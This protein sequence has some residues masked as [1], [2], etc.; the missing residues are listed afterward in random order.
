MME[1]LIYLK[2]YIFDI[3]EKCATI[4]CQNGGACA[5]SNLF[6]I[7]KNTATQDKWNILNH[8]Y[9]YVLD[10]CDL[11]TCQN[12]GACVVSNSNPV[13]MCTD[14]YT[15]DLCDTG[16]YIVFPI[17]IYCSNKVILSTKLYYFP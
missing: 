10:K 17:Q 8:F 3:S 11:I 7:L 2:I 15:G 16:I 13:C 1:V 12:G 9:F 6:Q 14:D 5:V 4:T